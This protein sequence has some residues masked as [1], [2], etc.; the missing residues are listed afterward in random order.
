TR[1]R[2]TPTD[3]PA[4]TRVIEAVVVSRG[5]QVEAEPIARYRAPGPVKLA[6]PRSVR[7]TRAKAAV[8]VRW[9]KVP[10]AARYRVTVRSDD[11]RVQ[12]F[13]VARKTTRFTIPQVTADDRAR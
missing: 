8:G 4:G 1:L 10:G 12:S 7:L 2:F 6:A 11:G 3:G 13:G 5:R 9:S